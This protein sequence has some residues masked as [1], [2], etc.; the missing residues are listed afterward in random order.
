[1]EIRLGK[2]WYLEHGDQFIQRCLHFF[3]KKKLDIEILSQELS[4]NGRIISLKTKF[5]DVNCQF[6]NVYSSNNPTQRKT[7][8]K[9]LNG[10]IDENFNLILAG[11]FNCVCDYLLDR[12]P[13]GKN[14]DQGSEELKSLMS[15]FGLQ[16][17]FR[18]R[19]PNKKAFSFPRG[20][21]KSRI[22]YHFI[23]SQALDCYTKSAS[24]HRLFPIQ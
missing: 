23:L 11:D 24:Q 8:I 13:P 14:K 17:I 21:S 19:Y 22:N 10:I 12:S 7:F 20:N 9:E 15:E 6:I 4:D 18:K 1:M 2:Q 3:F 5:D 16:D